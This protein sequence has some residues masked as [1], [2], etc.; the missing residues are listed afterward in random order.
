MPWQTHSGKR[1]DFIHSGVY[2]KRVLFRPWPSR[3]TYRPTASPSGIGGCRNIK[4]L[5][6]YIRLP[7]HLS[8]PWQRRCTPRGA[9][10]AAVASAQRRDPPAFAAVCRACAPPQP[11]M[12]APLPL[13]SRGGALA[14]SIDAPMRGEPRA[15]ANIPSP[16]AQVFVHPPG[17]ARQ[18]QGFR[19]G[20]PAG[21][22]LGVLASTCCPP[23]GWG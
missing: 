10:P 4:Q 6:R 17:G 15:K 12:A 8:T 19:Q 21:R 22:E 2:N 3:P 11:V 13:G 7:T 5:D 18:R 1:A 14:P 20:A 16:H 9:H 23:I